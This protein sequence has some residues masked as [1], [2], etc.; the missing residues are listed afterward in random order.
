MEE[1]SVSSA[2]WYNC[3]NMSSIYRL[4]SMYIILAAA[5]F[6][7]I[8]PSS[9]SIALDSSAFNPLNAFSRNL[10]YGSEG[11]DV[12]ELQRILNKDPGTLV[13]LNGPGSNGL[14]TQYFGPATLQAVIKFQEK[15]AEEI[16]APYG[17]SR[18]TGYVGETTR[19]KLN[20]MVETAAGSLPGNIVM[21]QLAESPNVIS[22]SPVQGG[23]GEKITVY[24]ENFLPLNTVMTNFKIFPDIPSFDGK[25]LEFIFDN[26]PFQEL[27][28]IRNKGKIDDIDIP[29]YVWVANENGTSTAFATF[30][31]QIK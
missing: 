3:I 19:A 22:I 7:I 4:V 28:R 26:P 13:A 8:A 2:E 20:S 23:N 21:G 1:D 29:F 15:F 9:V 11:L 18:G 16:L 5:I 10:S 31:I 17:L 27:Q 6:G 30:T 25:T 24:G 14:E 12:L